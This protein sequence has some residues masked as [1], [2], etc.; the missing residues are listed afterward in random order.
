MTIDD[1][2]AKVVTVTLLY[3][4]RPPFGVAAS[5]EGDALWKHVYAPSLAS[6]VLVRHAATC[7]PVP[8]KAQ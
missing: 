3:G 8:D 4:S 2:R 5:P 7:C 6:S 1:G